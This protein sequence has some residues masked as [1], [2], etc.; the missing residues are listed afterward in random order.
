MDKWEE[1]ELKCTEYLNEKFGD[2]AEFLH[3]G[4]SNSTI[5]DILVHTKSGQQFY[6]EVK[7]SPAQ[8][9]QFVLLPNIETRTFMYSSK[10]SIALNIPAKKIINYMNKYFDEFREA[11][12]KGKSIDIEN[13][14]NI[15]SD[16]IVEKYR[17]EGVKF[18]ITNNYNIAPIDK[19][20]EYF[21]VS[22]IYRVKRSG[23]SHVGKNK[24]ESVKNFIKSNGYNIVEMR[25]CGDKFFVKSSENLN[26]KRFILS[27]NEYLFSDRNGEYEIRKLSNTYNANVIFSI[28]Y[29]D[30]A[31]IKDSEFIEFLK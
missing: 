18:F 15:F 20:S 13:G 7:L 27:G 14:E 22:A 5:P 24:I 16:W 26:N 29:T 12:T 17:E 8:C 30:K 6:I 9:G 21:D 10:N 2:Y 3:Q 28:R 1:F 4:S 25:V 11:G 23:S 19:F 31:G